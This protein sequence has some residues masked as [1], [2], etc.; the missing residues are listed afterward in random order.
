M[1][2]TRLSSTCVRS[3]E[4]NYERGSYR[5][6][7]KWDRERGLTS[8]RQSPSRYNTPYHSSPSGLQSQSSGYPSP[9]HRVSSDTPSLGSS[10]SQPGGEGSRH[11]LRE[12]DS[13]PAASFCPSSNLPDK[14]GMYYYPPPST[15]TH[16]NTQSE[17]KAEEQPF[18]IILFNFPSL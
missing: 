17:V 6:S 14:S 18:L 7:R 11:M 5:D 12:T 3:Y 2:L 1:L 9:S 10:S 13:K 16:T 4:R 8:R 15:C